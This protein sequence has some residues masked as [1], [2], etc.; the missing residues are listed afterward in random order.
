MSIHGYTAPAGWSE[1]GRAVYRTAPLKIPLVAVSGH[2]EL[3]TFEPREG[4]DLAEVVGALVNELPYHLAEQVEAVWID[5][6]PDALRGDTAG[7]LTPESQ[8]RL[9]ALT[10]IE[11]LSVLHARLHENWVMSPPEAGLCTYFQPI[12][13]LAADHGVFAYEALSRYRHP[14]RGVLAGDVIFGVA[15]RARR[16]CVFERSAQ[17]MALRDKRERLPSGMPLFVNVLPQNLMVGELDRHPIVALVD[18]LAIAPAEIVLEISESEKVEDLSKLAARCSALRER[19]FRLALDDFGTGFSGLSAVAAIK[20]DFIKLDRSLVHACEGSKTRRA[21]LESLA[22]LGERLGSACIAEGVEDDRDLECLREIGIPYAQGYAIARPAPQPEVPIWHVP[23]ARKAHSQS[24]KRRSLTLADDIEFVEPAHLHS[25]LGDL[26]ARFNEDP[27]LTSIVVVDQDHPVGFVD[28]ARAVRGLP[29]QEVAR[30]GIGRLV[31]PLHHRLSGHVPVRQI[32]WRVFRSPSSDEPWVVCDDEGR[33]LG[34][35]NA[36]RVLERSL[37][38]VVDHDV[39]A[40]TRMPTGPRLRR[41]MHDLQTR[42]EGLVMLYVDLDRFKA[43]NDRF[44]FV[45]GDAMIKLLAESLRGA[46][47]SDPAVVVGHIGGDDFVVLAPPT[48]AQW[49]PAIRRAVAQFDA[50]AVHLYC[51]G[52]NEPLDRETCAPPVE[53]R[54][55]VSVVVVQAGLDGAVIDSI[56]LAQR[57]ARLK[58]AAKKV[59]GSVIVWEGPPQRVLPLPP[60]ARQFQWQDQAFAALDEWLLRAN[61][62]DGIPD[63]WFDSYPFFELVYRLDANGVQRFDNCVNPR[64]ADRVRAR[65]RGVDRS[66]APYYRAIAQ[67][68]ARFISDIYLSRATE[69]FCV[70]VAFR[71]GGLA[72]EGDLIVADL[73]LSGLLDLVGRSS[74]TLQTATPRNIEDEPCAP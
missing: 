29:G 39:H 73:S 4:R 16:L 9:D 47:A 12:V 45:R 54:A 6:D 74:A 25:S 56:E 66:T 13:D 70:T 72:A 69:D 44:G 71:V 63:G 14:T 34:L 24:V 65:G 11:P 59:S 22:H 17:R 55:N 46:F 33:Y 32:L 37:D 19:G 40:L 61:S 27:A 67:G 3:W 30:G 5:E 31:R 23:S 60:P 35:I 26:R 7:V 15:R 42:R 20:P 48:S 51:Q 1:L 18:K 58:S 36:Q 2:V 50:L 41:A 53:D 8:M 38:E 28:R 57:A 52:E 49:L 21:M 43:F 64:L 68:A 10:R 62:D